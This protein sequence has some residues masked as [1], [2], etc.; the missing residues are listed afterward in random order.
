M[1]KTAYWISEKVQLEGDKFL[2]GYERS[3]LH[4]GSDLICSTTDYM[5][6]IRISLTGARV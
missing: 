6:T 2:I 1:E 4:A 5:Y 3:G